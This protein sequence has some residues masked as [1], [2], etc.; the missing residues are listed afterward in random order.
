MSAVDRAALG[1]TGAIATPELADALLAGIHR[2]VASQET[3]NRINVFPVA[4]GDTGTNLAL[5]MLSARR[6]LTNERSEDVGPL[7][8]RVA[9]AL[10]DGARGNSGAIM[11]QFFQGLADALRET[12]TLTIASLTNALA[13]ASSYARD[14]LVEPR[15]GTILSVMRT[16]AEATRDAVADAR[17]LETLLSR[18]LDACRSAL[19]ATTDQLAELRKAGVVDAGA[20]GFVN[21]V[22]GMLAFVRDR[23]MPDFDALEI[24][25]EY[26]AEDT[27]GAEQDLDYRYCTECVITGSGIDRRKLRESLAELGGSL[28]LAGTHAK[29]KIHIHVNDPTEVFA[30]AGRFGTVSGEK[31]DDM[32]RQQSATHHKAGSVGVITD[33]AADMS[34][35][36]L[37]DLGIHIVPMRINFGDKSYLDKVSISAGQFFD[38]LATNP[39]HPQT[40]QPAP[41]D[42]RRLL[43]FLASHFESV[44]LFCITDT[45]SGTHSA[46]V[47]AVGRVTGGERIAV[48]NTKNAS[49]GQGLIVRDAAERASAGA[50]S[51][52]IQTATDDAIASTRSFAL[53]KDLN[54]AVKGGRVP[55]WAR[56]IADVLRL[57]PV[58]GTTPDGKIK[59]ISALLGRSNRIDKFA[60]F[61][62]RRTESGGV[63]RLSI[64]HAQSADDAAALADRLSTMLTIDGDVDVSPTGAAFGVHGGPGTLVAA[65]QK[66]N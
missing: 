47:S 53:L 48:I 26:L 46:A 11:A 34:D 1:A 14:A 31:A 12:R 44:F 3:L 32:H 29:A 62:A 8:E 60:R 21:L 51:A 6:V 27:A 19:I 56:F 37:E 40:S 15:E 17:D 65:I 55:S 42:Y 18:A 22:E 61:I 39:V 9:D 35:A 38:E 49:V 10:L 30:T 52:D 13:E 50:S 66:R 36:L 7:L 41:G 63:Y 57:N 24:A 25:D 2:V 5:T 16:M 59:P 54:Y 45:V 23:E 33:S 58:L 20:Q 64:S 43:Q 4:D 28:V